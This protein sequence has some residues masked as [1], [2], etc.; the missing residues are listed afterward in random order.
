MPLAVQ[1]YHAPAPYYVSYTEASNRRRR[2]DS[3]QRL[4]H[5][6][7]PPD[8]DALLAPVG[9][10]VV[11]IDNGVDARWEVR[12]VPTPDERARRLLADLRDGQG[13]P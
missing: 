12:Q 3:S 4:V 11:R 10:T 1:P 9:L 7:E 8:Y 2:N 13:L 5:G 6:R